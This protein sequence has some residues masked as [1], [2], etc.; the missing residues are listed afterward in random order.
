M[1]TGRN[2]IVGVF[3]LAML[4]A[5]VFW[6]AVLAGRT[7]STEPY[8]SHY[9]NV[10]GVAA[11]TQVFFEGYKVGIVEA[12]EPSPGEERRFRVDLAI[13][14]DWQIP[15]DSVAEITASGLLSAIIIDIR[16]GRSA[17]MLPP[18]SEIRGGLPQSIVAA[19][20]NVAGLVTSV[21]H[22]NIEPLLVMLGEQAPEILENLNEFSSELNQA[23]KNV[24]ELVGTE[25]SETIGRILVDVAGTTSNLSS[26]SSDLDGTKERLDLLLTSL[27]ELVENNSGNVSQVVVDLRDML[28]ALAP[29]VDAISRNLEVTTRNLNEFS[30][31]IR[32]NPGVI[33]RGRES[34]S[35]AAE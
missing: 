24:N 16:A 12:V 18:G 28:E 2:L 8:Y 17:T 3:V 7:G 1:G 10:T 6:I 19:L 15:E 9:D 5:F 33:V 30:L 22:E 4:A 26:V 20:S 14:S 35:G 25:N 31:Q 23:A 27:N 32:E 34:A 29:R 21:I 11:G 13:T